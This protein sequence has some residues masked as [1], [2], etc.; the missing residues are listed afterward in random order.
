MQP[1]CAEVSR[2]RSGRTRAPSIA[3]GLRL[4]SRVLARVSTR[5]QELGRRAWSEVARRLLGGSSLVNPLRAGL[6][7]R[8]H[9]L[10]LRCAFAS[11]VLYPVAACF[12]GLGDLGRRCPVQVNVYFA[13]SR[14]FRRGGFLCLKF[15]PV[16]VVP[17]DSV[18]SS[19]EGRRPYLLV[20][21]DA[22]SGLP[23]SLPKITW[24]RRDGLGL[25]FWGLAR[26][27]GSR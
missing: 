12:P 13:S 21:M 15:A 5:A 10:W 24:P 22:S 8:P 18:R 14:M 20:P 4:A 26:A 19:C 1:G 11:L 27:L 2:S 3:E 25:C 7:V 23:A 6:F 16:G 9:G 17:R